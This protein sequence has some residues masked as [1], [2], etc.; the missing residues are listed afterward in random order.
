MSKST[1]LSILVGSISIA[2]VV[3]FCG[4][5]FYSWNIMQEGGA[6]ATGG[7]LG[8]C[9]SVVLGSMGVVV[10][11]L[12]SLVFVLAVGPR[13][14]WITAVCTSIL[15]VAIVF[16]TQRI[17]QLF[18]GAAIIQSKQFYLLAATGVG[19]VFYF[20]LPATLYY[21]AI[22]QAKQHLA[23]PHKL[24]KSAAKDIGLATLCYAM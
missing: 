22:A 10:P 8:L 1:K 20:M 12:I 9:Y 13:K 2:C 6:A 7:F 19:N 17:A 4:A 14:A 21:Y 23:S 11:L 18:F 15:A 24:D 16:A 5:S 3:A